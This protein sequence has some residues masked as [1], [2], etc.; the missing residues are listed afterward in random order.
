MREEREYLRPAGT[1]TFFPSTP[2]GTLSNIWI[3]VRATK[4]IEAASTKFRFL[5]LETMNVSVAT[6]YSETEPVPN[7]SNFVLVHFYVGKRSLVE[8][9]GSQ[10]PSLNGKQQNTSSP[11]FTFVTSSPIAATVP[12][13]SKPILNGKL[14]FWSASRD[15]FLFQVPF[16]PMDSRNAKSRP[17]SPQRAPYIRGID[18]RCMNSHQN[19]ITSRDFRRWQ[20]CNLPFWRWPEMAGAEGPHCLWD[21]GVSHSGRGIPER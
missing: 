18:S 19:L 11:I 10:P 14:L 4:G 8:D 3:A 13:R 12:A 9:V 6:A 17:I 16:K 20:I 21:G 15:N 5:G 1:N 2:P 7:L